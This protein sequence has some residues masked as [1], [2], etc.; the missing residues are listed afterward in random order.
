MSTHVPGFQKGF[1]IIFIC[2]I[3]HQQDKGQKIL[4]LKSVLSNENQQRFLNSHSLRNF[5]YILSTSLK[6]IMCKQCVKK[7]S[8]LLFL[9][10]TIKY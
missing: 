8:V 7:K 10:M 5:K 1:C 6:L 2:Q 9:V 4:V 3:S